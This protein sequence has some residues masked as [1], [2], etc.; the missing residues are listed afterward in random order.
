MTKAKLV[1]SKTVPTVWLRSPKA[2]E[3][4]YCRAN[5]GRDCATLSGGLS[6][7]HVAGIAAAAKADLAR[8]A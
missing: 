7:L 5:P 6:I 3:C 8:R 1:K 2:L 4:P